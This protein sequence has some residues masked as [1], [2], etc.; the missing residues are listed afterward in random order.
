MHHLDVEIFLPLVLLCFEKLL[1]SSPGKKIQLIDPFLATHDD[2][3][4]FVSS[5]LTVAQQVLLKHPTQQLTTLIRN[6]L[7]ARSQLSV[8]VNPR[9]VVDNA[10]LS[11]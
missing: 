3:E 4:N 6:L 2:A 8:N 1:Q 11:V 9:L 10:V 5:L 7:A